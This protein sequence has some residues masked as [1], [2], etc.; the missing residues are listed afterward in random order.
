MQQAIAKAVC[1]KN[2]IVFSFF[3]FMCVIALSTVVSQIF[4]YIKNGEEIFIPGIAVLILAVLL[5]ML[6]GITRVIKYI[7]LLKNQ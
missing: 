5:G 3:S 6:F 2:I 7:K 4:Q 1:I